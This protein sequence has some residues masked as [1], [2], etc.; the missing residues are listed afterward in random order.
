MLV[1]KFEKGAV[2]SMLVLVIFIVIVAVIAVFYVF[3]NQDITAFADMIK[4]FFIVSAGQ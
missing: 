4:S 2:N 3:F 1:E